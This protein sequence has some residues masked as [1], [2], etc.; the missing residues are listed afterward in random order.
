M[1]RI[2]LFLLAVVMA[3]GMAACSS[4]DANPVGTWDVTA[5]SLGSTADIRWFIYDNGTFI[6]IDGDAGIWSVDKKKITVQYNAGGAIFSGS[7]DD[8]TMEGTFNGAVSGSWAARRI[9]SSPK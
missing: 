7:V 9:S 4:K 6:D 8:D 1:K 5:K 2:G 3:F